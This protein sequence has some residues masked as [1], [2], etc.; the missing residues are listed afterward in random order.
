MLTF[1]FT[2][3]PRTWRHNPDVRNKPTE[4]SSSASSADKKAYAI[5]LAGNDSLYFRATRTLLFQLLHD[6][7]TR[8][9]NNRPVVIMTSSTVPQETRKQLAREGAT[10][11]PVEAVKGIKGVGEDNRWRELY[12][13]LR[14]WE[15]EE[16]ERVLVLDSDQLLVKPIHGIWDD[17]NAI[18][19]S[20]LAAVSDCVVGH[21]SPPENTDYLNGGLI[22][23]TPSKARFQELIATNSSLFDTNYM[24][25]GLL[26]WVYRR[27]GPMPWA[28]LDHKW[29][30]NWPS[31]KDITVG[32][33]HAVHDKFWR[34]D[35]KDWIDR[36]LVEMWWRACGRMEGYWMA[37]EF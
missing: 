35:N 37:K 1:L 36:E 23:V 9:P 17:P 25:Q 10:I 12:T 16:Y 6:P 32:K 8:D 27:D 14:V 30:T 34:A 18:N 29:T 28:A 22:M 24:E 5:F 26:N 33:V 15:M 11:A 20:G 4:T 31:L 13:K 21:D 19:N 2:F 3:P 7:D